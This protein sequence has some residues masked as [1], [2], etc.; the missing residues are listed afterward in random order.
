M[1]ALNLRLTREEISFLMAP[2]SNNV[3]TYNGFMYPAITP[4][5]NYPF[6]TQPMCTQ[7]NMSAYPNLGSAGLFADLTGC[8]TPFVRWIEDYPLPHRL[9]MPFH[10][11]SYD[12]KG[13]L[14]NYQKAGSILNYKDLKAKFRSHYSQQK[15]F[16]KTYLAMHNIKQKEG[17]STRAFVTMYTDD[18]LQILGLHEDQ[19]ISGI[20]HGLR[21]RNL[22]E[23]LSTY[24]P[25]TYKGP[26]EKITHRLKQRK[27]QPT[28]L[29]MTEGRVSTDLG[30]ILPRTTTKERKTETNS[31]RIGERKKEDKDT[32]PVE[33]PILMISRRDHTTKRKSLEELTPGFGEITFPLVAGVNNSSDPVI[34]KAKIS[35]RQVN[36]VDMDNENSCEVI[37]E[38][39][40]LELKPSIKT[41]RLDSKVSLVGFSGEHSWPIKEVPLEITI[42]DSPFSKTE[43]LNFVIVRS[44]SPDNILLGR[45]TMQKIGEGTKKLREVSPDD[46]K[47]ILSCTDV[48]ERIIVNSKYPEQMVVIG[49]Q[50]PT[51]FKERKP[52]N[53][54]H[55]LNEYKHIKPIKQKKHGLGPDRNVAVCK[56]VEELMKAGILQKVK[57]QTWVA[58]PVMVKKSDEGWRMCVD[59]TDINKAYP[60]DCYHL[61]EIDWK[62]ESLSEFRLKCFLDAYKGYHQI[63]MAKEDED[64]TIFFAGEGTFCYRKMPFGLKNDGATYQRLVDKVYNDQIGRNLKAYVD[65]MDKQSDEKTRHKNPNS[66][67][68]SRNAKIPSLASNAA[69]VKLPFVGFSDGR[70]QVRSTV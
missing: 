52:F 8:V 3:P 32:T 39:Y 69:D 64:K 29:R 28:E 4:S 17:E 26:M 67:G 18:T 20:V 48:K 50:L 68:W 31:F 13:D 38:H 9:K 7:P 23:F 30:K 54:E 19:C 40:F 21:T 63:Q 33:A 15:K 22:V 47:G 49:K 57:N 44:N 14:D 1:E 24:L 11:G 41:L 25:T 55:K 51:N 65:D 56:E 34:I 37:Y 45:T 60:K 62:V 16:T 61:P 27:W 59:F 6:Y 70:I 53:T 36:R 5:D 35:G 46:I 2:T 66:R 10:V 58:N 43:T 12:G 42:G